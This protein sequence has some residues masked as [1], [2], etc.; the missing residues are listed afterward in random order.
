MEHRLARAANGGGGHDK[1]VPDYTIEGQMDPIP[2]NLQAHRASDEGGEQSP[3]QWSP[4]AKEGMSAAE[5]HEE[6]LW[7]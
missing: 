3:G 4:V 2:L 5:A 7:A 6:V 1:W